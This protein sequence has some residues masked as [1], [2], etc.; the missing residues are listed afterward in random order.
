VKASMAWGWQGHAQQHTVQAG[1]APGRVPERSAVASLLVQLGPLGHA[2]PIIPISCEACT[3]MR[4]PVINTAVNI[5]C[6]GG[7]TDGWAWHSHA[8]MQR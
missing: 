7:C 4:R 5:G 2:Q 3:R 1:Y 6:A 8:P